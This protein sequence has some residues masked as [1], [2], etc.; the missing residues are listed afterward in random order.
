MEVEGRGELDVNSVVQSHPNNSFTC[1]PSLPKSQCK[2]KRNCRKRTCSHSATH[3]GSDGRSPCWLT[4]GGGHVVGLQFIPLRT[5]VRPKMTQSLQPLD[6]MSRPYTMW[7]PL[8]TAG[9]DL[10]VLK[11]EHQNGQMDSRPACCLEGLPWGVAGW[12]TKEA[13]S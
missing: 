6:Q 1:L 3:Q 12:N 8:N 13:C 7:S 4:E 11:L 9:L 2:Q 10:V 5:S